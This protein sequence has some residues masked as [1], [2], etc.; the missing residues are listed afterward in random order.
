MEEEDVESRRDVVHKLI[1][2][3]DRDGMAI[4]RER[5]NGELYALM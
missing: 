4:P 2:Y 1:E 5:L 3:R